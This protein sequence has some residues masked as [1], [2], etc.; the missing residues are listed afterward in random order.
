MSPY[1]LGV[2]P[3]MLNQQSYENGSLSSLNPG[4]TG[5]HQAA[6]E[7]KKH[8]FWVGIVRLILPLLRQ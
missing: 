1:K 2:F 8:S 5:K 3:N 7:A 4:E 6:V